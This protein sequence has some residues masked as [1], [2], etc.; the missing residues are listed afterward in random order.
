MS[1]RIVHFEVPYDDRDRAAQFYGEVFGWQVQ[2]VPGF[3]YS[4]AVTGPT[5][6]SGP[7]EPGYIN[8]GMMERTA[9]YRSPVITVDVTSIDD[10]LAAVESHGGSV[11]RGKEPV[12]DMGWSAYFNDPEG[13]LMGLWE[14]A[15]SEQE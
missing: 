5:G 9:Q 4:F 12:G 6:D 15:R 7:T 2:E 8:G 1:G 11:A 13:N 14:S 3:A 10:A